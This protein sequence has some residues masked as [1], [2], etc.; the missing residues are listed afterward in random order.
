MS[1][2]AIADGVGSSMGADI[3]AK[4]AVMSFLRSTT[5]LDT[6]GK[7][8]DLIEIRKLWADVATETALSLGTLHDQYIGT[9]SALRT[10]LLTVVECT[11]SYFISYLGNGSIWLVRGDF[12]TAVKEHWPGYFTDLMLP[13]SLL[14]LSGREGLFGTIGPGGMSAE[15]RHIAIG[16]DRFVGE[17]LILTTDGISSPDKLITGTDDQGKLWIEINEHMFNL[18]MSHLPHFLASLGTGRYSGT[19]EALVGELQAFFDDCTFEDDATIGIFVSPATIDLYA[20]LAK[21]GDVK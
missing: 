6:S 2:I 5:T 15:P 11:D 18:L 12:G 16:K 10:T 21:L 9:P 20:N 17:I 1:A 3:A 19:D 7:R 13:H 4:S 14:T 8:L